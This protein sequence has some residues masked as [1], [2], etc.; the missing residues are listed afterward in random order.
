MRTVRQRRAL[1]ESEQIARKLAAKGPFTSGKFAHTAGFTPNRARQLLESY[2]QAG[3]LT[4]LGKRPSTRGKPAVLWGAPG[5]TLTEKD[6]RR[7]RVVT[8]LKS[9]KVERVEKIDLKLPPAATEVQSSFFVQ[10][11]F[12]ALLQ[13]VRVVGP[14]KKVWLI[15]ATRV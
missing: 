8:K 7:P 4:E 6:Q 10:F 1:E 14:R 3:W 15:K 11:I 12:S 9:T 13:G 2:K 5:T